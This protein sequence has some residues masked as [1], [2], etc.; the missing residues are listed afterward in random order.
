MMKPCRIVNNY[1]LKQLKFNYQSLELLIKPG[2]QQ[3]L[4]ST[5]GFL[6]LLLSRK[7]VCMHMC[8]Y[9]TPRLVL[10]DIEPHI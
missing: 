10:L 4:A 9:P 1:I 3:P 8:V 5:P 6:Q 2:T 7:S